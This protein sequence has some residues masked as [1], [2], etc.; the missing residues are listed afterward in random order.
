MIDYY[1]TNEYLIKLPEA[2]F[3]GPCSELV[4]AEDGPVA[5]GETAGNPTECRTR[6]MRSG[7]GRTR[8]VPYRLC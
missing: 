2:I 8:A 7:D 1:H 3:S 5:Q 4:F 6:R